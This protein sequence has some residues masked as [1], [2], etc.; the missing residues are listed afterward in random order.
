MRKISFALIF[1]ALVPI[2]TLG[3][4]TTNKG[5]QEQKIRGQIP[6]IEQ[7]GEPI[8]LRHSSTESIPNQAHLFNLSFAVTFNTTKP[9]LSFRVHYEQEFE[10]RT[11]TSTPIVVKSEMSIDN[12]P[13]NHKIVTFACRK[14][15]KAKV[16]VSLVEFEDG[17]IWRAEMAKVTESQGRKN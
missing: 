8:R 7:I 16:W 6:S 14:D 13:T 5:K 2:V 1:L 11:I 4:I 9:I 12:S 10:D 15:A 17:T 3:Q